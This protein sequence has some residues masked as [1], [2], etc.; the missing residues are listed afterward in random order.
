MKTI[1]YLILVLALVIFAARP[2][3]TLNPFS[4]TFETSYFAIGLVFLLIGLSLIRYD[5]YRRGVK[6][7][8]NVT[9]EKLEKLSEE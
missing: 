8:L 2:K 1:L 6:E 9:I 3:I 7:G 4:V 5:S